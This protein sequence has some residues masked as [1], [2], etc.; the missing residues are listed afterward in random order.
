MS[1]PDPYVSRRPGELLYASDWNTVQVRF[2]E[3]LRD[4]DHTGGALGAKLDGGSFAR[5]G[6]LRVASAQLSGGLQVGG[7]D[8]M[9][10]LD[11]S[12]PTTGGTITGDL[13]VGGRLTV[14]GE[15][16]WTPRATGPYRRALELSLPATEHTQTDN[17]GNPLRYAKRAEEVPLDSNSYPVLGELAVPAGAWHLRLRLIA[18]WWSELLSRG[19]TNSPGIFLDRRSEGQ[20]KPTQVHFLNGPAVSQ[21]MSRLELEE[22]TVLRLWSN[23][24]NSWVLVEAHLLLLPA[25]GR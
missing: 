1:G 14:G 13:R 8:L 23:T 17:Y 22:P 10:A 9:A 19:I 4:H 7:E 6:A 18:C 24:Q 11:A 25:G 12:L 15:L 20:V 21:V 2:R 5:G 3:E 16:R